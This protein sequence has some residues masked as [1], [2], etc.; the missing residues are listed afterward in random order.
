MEASAQTEVSIASQLAQSFQK[1]FGAIP[2]MY[3]APGRV[4]LIGEHTDYIEGFVF[5]AAIDRFTWVAA[6]PR[7]DRRVAF[8]SEN[9]GQLAEFD[10]DALTR[11][12]GKSWADYP[13]GVAWA[14][15]NA[16]LRLRGVN[17]AIRS[18]VPIGSGLSS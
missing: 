18:N 6:A 14:L 4:N 3:R 11:A 16:G 1:R 2:R 15:E 10:L 7:K 8:Y 5:P 13:A 9:M 17:L 12:P